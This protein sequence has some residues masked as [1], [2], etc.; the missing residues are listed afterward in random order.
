MGRLGDGED[1]A[2]PREPLRSRPDDPR[3]LPHASRL[4]RTA[5]PFPARRQISLPRLCQHQPGRPDLQPGKR[6][7]PC[8][9]SAR[10]DRGHPRQ[11]RRRRARRRDQ[12]R[13]LSGLRAGGRH[14]PAARPARTG[15]GSHPDLPA[16]ISVAAGAGQT[17]A[18]GRAGFRAD[19][20][21][22]GGAP[23]RRLELPAI[24]QA[25]EV[26]L[27]D[28]RRTGDVGGGAGRANAPLDQSR[29]ILPAA[30][31]HA[32]AL[33]PGQASAPSGSSPKAC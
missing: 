27:L 6:R 17:R 14:R 12:Q 10:R 24:R 15:A 4:S 2:K 25:G 19:R 29:S 28:R 7:V 30:R 22:R 20:R 26:V 33:S 11:V 9:R 8:R 21:R 18:G 16:Q 31:P 13:R 5:S 1:P 32:P 23:P 3:H